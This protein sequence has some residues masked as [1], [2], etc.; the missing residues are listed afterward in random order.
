MSGDIEMG[1]CDFCKEIKP[2]QRTY[3]EPTK[4]TKPEHPS[5]PGS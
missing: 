3:L 2:V 4:Y 1:K 5:Q